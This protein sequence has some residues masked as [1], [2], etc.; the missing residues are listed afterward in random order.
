[1]H[2]WF[3]DKQPTFVTGEI[4][5][6]ERQHLINNKK[7]TL[8]SPSLSTRRPAILAELAWVRWQA[9]QIDSAVG[10][11][12]IYLHIGEVIPG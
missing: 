6:A 10:L 8:L 1:M 2:N 12:P 7:I 4:S 11:S 3:V 5:D 9:G